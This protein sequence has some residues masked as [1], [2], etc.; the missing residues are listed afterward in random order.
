MT[1]IEESQ[2]RIPTFS[3]CIQGYWALNPIWTDTSWILHNTQYSSK[4][5]ALKYSEDALKNNVMNECIL[6]ISLPR[7]LLH[8]YESRLLVLLVAED[9]FL[10][11]LHYIWMTLGSVR[12]LP[13]GTVSQIKTWMHELRWAALNDLSSSCW[14]K[15]LKCL[16]QFPRA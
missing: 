8:L 6:V 11:L 4:F 3:C 5:K 10:S 15:F 9:S 13:D 12:H 2:W 7:L 16:W 1:T 14:I